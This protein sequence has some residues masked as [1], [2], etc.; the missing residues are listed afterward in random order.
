MGPLEEIDS[1]IH[2]TAAGCSTAEG[3]GRTQR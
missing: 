3:A 2:I 1:V